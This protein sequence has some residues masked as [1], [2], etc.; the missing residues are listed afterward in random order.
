MMAKDVVLGADDTAETKDPMS[1]D[2]VWDDDRD[3][4][5]RVDEES[6]RS[7]VGDVV[8]TNYH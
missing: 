4:D 2:R 5:D 3:M 7:E 8:G 1:V 6:G